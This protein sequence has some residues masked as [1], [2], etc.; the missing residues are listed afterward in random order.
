MTG[1]A[2]EVK[3]IRW[4]CDCESHPGGECSDR[5]KKNEIL[6]AIYDGSMAEEESRTA[7]RNLSQGLKE[8]FYA[9]NCELRAA[10][11]I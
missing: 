9:T 4:K 6:A 1:L 2:I 11:T 7:Y 8:Q 10:P 5:N 3:L